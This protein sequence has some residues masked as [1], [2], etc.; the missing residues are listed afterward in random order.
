MS[1]TR[2]DVGKA[3]TKTKRGNLVVDS[4]MQQDDTMD[5]TGVGRSSLGS[6]GNPAPRKMSKNQKDIASSSKAPPQSPIL[7]FVVC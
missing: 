4:Q 2:A 5:G 7:S 3:T 6:G 1:P